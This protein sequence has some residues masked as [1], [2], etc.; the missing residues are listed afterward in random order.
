MGNKYLIILV[1][2]LL[3]TGT[4][5][6]APASEN[7]KEKIRVIAHTDKEISDAI[8]KGCKVVREAKTLKAL[9]CSRETATSLGLQEDI[10][11][12]AVDSG[13]NAQ[14]RADLVH[15]SGNTGLGR[16][17]VVL[18]TGYNYNHPELSSSYLGGKDFVNNDN[19][20]WDDHGH[21]SHVAGLITA[22]GVYPPAKGVAPDTGI[23]AGKVLSASG[24]GYFTDVVAAIYWAVDGPDGFPNTPDD[25]NA[26]AI[27]MSLGTGSPYLYK[28]YCD[29]AEFW[30]T[31]VT[32]AIR[33]AV[34]RGVL[35]VVAAGNSGDS[36]VSIPG[37]I[38]YSTTVG[39]VDSSDN[40]AGFSGIGNA[41]DI[42]APGVNLVSS[43]LGTS[44]RF[45]SGTSMATPVVSG[46]VALIK[47]AHPEYTP[48]QIEAALFMSAIDLGSIG[49]DS[50]YGWGRVDALVPAEPAVHDVAVTS[51]S[52][53]SS[54]VQGTRV[55]VLVNVAN[56]GNRAESFTVTVTDE[57]DSVTIGSQAVNLNAGSS[58]TISFNWDT[59]TSSLGVHVIKA[60]AGVVP[61]ET[62]TADNVKTADVVIST[63]PTEKTMHVAGIDMSADKIKGDNYAT[64]T[65]TIVDS[66]GNPVQGALVSG[67]WSGLTSDSDSGTTGADGRVALSSDA[68]KA[69]KERTFTFTVDNV[70]LDGWVYNQSENVVTSGSITV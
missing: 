57:T 30:V 1:A 48:A 11:V 18:D 4:A 5:N 46:V 20:P 65:V 62:D 50:T 69:K 52:A 43:W 25:F 36:G 32:N 31:D 15:A 58:T 3:L 14:I 41:V 38:S 42:T 63:T 21:G 33:Y 39:A 10:R 34:D 37:C 59:S 6:A 49:K 45:A 22:D 17:V 66:A 9:V 55:D 53:P 35:V 13:A 51:I 68:A 23:I 60:Q 12:F 19:D 27:S 54:I 2:I 47:F 8:A 24:G 44:Y 26:D 67:H 7:E 70:G 40:I 64:A 28:G 56:E 16:R 61:G 29:N